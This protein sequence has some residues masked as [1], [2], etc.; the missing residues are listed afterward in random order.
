MAK[1][2]LVFSSCSNIVKIT[3]NQARAQKKIWACYLSTHYRLITDLSINSGC[4]PKY[5]VLTKPVRSGHFIQ[6]KVRY[7]CSGFVSHNNGI[8]AGLTVFCK[9]TQLAAR[10]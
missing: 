9:G 6:V 1:S 3:R 8:E 5:V 4:G 7:F 10:V 2:N